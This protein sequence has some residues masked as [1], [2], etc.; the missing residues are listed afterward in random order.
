MK[1]KGQFLVAAVGLM[2]LG[3]AGLMILKRQISRTHEV[4]RVQAGEGGEKA[5]LDL[6]TAPSEAGHVESITNEPA[7]AD[8]TNGIEISGEAK[9]QTADQAKKKGGP[10]KKVVQDSV[11]REA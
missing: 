7:S 10:K 8:A 11:W 4:P 5:S 6:K 2:I 9:K 1:Q 3:C